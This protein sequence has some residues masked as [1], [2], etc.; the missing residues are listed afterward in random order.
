VATE[1][2]KRKWG[3]GQ[4]QGFKLMYATSCHFMVGAL[5]EDGGWRPDLVVSNTD[6]RTG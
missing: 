1:Q 4:H 6:K 5:E 3:S 2:S